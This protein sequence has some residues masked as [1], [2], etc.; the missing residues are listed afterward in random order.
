MEI[1]EDLPVGEF[2]YRKNP[3]DSLWTVSAKGPSD[4]TLTFLPQGILELLKGHIK[5][6]QDDDDSEDAIVSEASTDSMITRTVTRKESED[7]SGTLLIGLQSTNTNYASLK[8]EFDE[9]V[10]KPNIHVLSRD[11]KCALCYWSREGSTGWYDSVPG[12]V[13]TGLAI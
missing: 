5:K 13:R 1:N 10:S 11:A 6:V 12:C 4:D 9:S 8:P 3:G 2:V 7:I